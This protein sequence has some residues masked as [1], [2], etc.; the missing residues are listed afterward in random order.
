MNQIQYFI[1]QSSQIDL[2]RTRRTRNK[3]HVRIVPT[4]E[5]Y[6]AAADDYAPEELQ[7]GIGAIASRTI[8][9]SSSVSPSMEVELKTRGRRWEGERSRI[10]SA[11]K[12][13]ATGTMIFKK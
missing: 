11:V 12:L 7:G 5:I 3:I 2:R 4:N 9:G 10:K 8:T 1:D 13:A 6:T